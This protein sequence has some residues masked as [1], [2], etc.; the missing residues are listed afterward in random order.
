METFNS[1]PVLPTS[2][3]S[4]HQQ[5]KLKQQSQPEIPLPGQQ[6]TPIIVEPES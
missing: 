6:S 2:K 5:L 3:L 4:Y 1:K